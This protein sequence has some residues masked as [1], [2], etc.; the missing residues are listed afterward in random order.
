MLCEKKYEEKKSRSQPGETSKGWICFVFLGL[1]C[2]VEVSGNDQA[3]KK[4]NKSDCG[5]FKI[6]QLPHYD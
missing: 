5:T 1:Q 3:G 2:E 6:L 4:S